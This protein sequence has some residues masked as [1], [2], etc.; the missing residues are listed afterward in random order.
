MNDELLGF[1]HGGGWF[2]EGDTRLAPAFMFS[3]HAA[4]SCSL[5]FEVWRLASEYWHCETLPM[6]TSI[7][8]MPVHNP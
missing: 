8:G 3:K 6:Q 5:H 4:T 7:H 1:L 2:T